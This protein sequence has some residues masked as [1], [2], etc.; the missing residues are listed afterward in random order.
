[1]ALGR[2]CGWLLVGSLPLGSCPDALNVAAKD[3]EAIT[4]IKRRPEPS[5]LACTC[6]SA[7]CTQGSRCVRPISNL[8]VS[9]LHH[10][11]YRCMLRGGKGG[12]AGE[13][14]GAFEGPLGA[15]LG[16]RAHLEKAAMS[17]RSPIR[18]FLTQARPSCFVCEF[19]AAGAC[20]MVI[21]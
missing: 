5:T 11:L 9:R 18:N 2:L 21:A 19:D 12:K 14:A 4:H 8:S 10:V 15:A 6:S 1:M 3:V 13:V 20:H 17:K 16:S 7:G